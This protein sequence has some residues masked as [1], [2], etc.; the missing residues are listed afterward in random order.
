MTGLPVLVQ[1]A[2]VAGV[3]AGIVL[4]ILVLARMER[5]RKPRGPG[6]GR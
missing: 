5:H 3:L 2:I 6:R 1:A 4:V